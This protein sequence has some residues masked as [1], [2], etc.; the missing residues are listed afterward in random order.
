MLPTR[1]IC[2]LS[3]NATNVFTEFA[4]TRVLLLRF[5]LN[6]GRDISNQ[7]GWLPGLQF[8]MDLTAS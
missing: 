3:I 7:R 6:T 4:P 2:L 5:Q 8:E 1:Q